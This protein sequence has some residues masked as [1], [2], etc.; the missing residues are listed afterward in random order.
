MEAK[1]PHLSVLA[2]RQFRY[3]LQQTLVEV[4]IK[5]PRPFNVLE[6]FIIRAGIQFEPAPTADEL[7]SILGLDPVFV[8]STVKILQDLHTLEPKSPITV[9]DEGRLFYENGSVQKPPH[10]T[11]IYAIANPWEEKI[12]FQLE[13]LNSLVINQPDLE[14][15]LNLNYPVSDISELSIQEFQNIIQ[16]SE[17]G[18]HIP[19]AGKIVT[20]YKVLPPTQMICK[21]ISIFVI[22]DVIADKL[23]IQ[24]RNGKQ[25]LESP[26]NFLETLQA[27]GKVNLQTLCDLSDETINFER[28]LALQKNK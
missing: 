27:E 9:T 18:L 4:T 17:L 2:A 8:R 20:A 23:I 13:P 10:S 5:E 26:S 1:N 3:S 14:K 28:Q 25:I 22:Y 7:A 12:I 6:E 19:A 16:D 24:A 15:I 11:Q 21:R